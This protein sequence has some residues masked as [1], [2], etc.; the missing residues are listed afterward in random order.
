MM[1]IYRQNIS[2]PYPNIIQ[3]GWPAGFNQLATGP[4]CHMGELFHFVFF[5]ELACKFWGRA[6]YASVGQRNATRPARMPAWLSGDLCFL[7]GILDFCF[8]IWDFVLYMKL[9]S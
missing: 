9:V 8:W 2:Q 4:P 7:F 5:W 6:H 3:H 1:N